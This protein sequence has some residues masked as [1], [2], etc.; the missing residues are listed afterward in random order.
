MEV[1]CMQLTSREI[2]TL[3]HS[4]PVTE[5]NSMLEHYAKAYA[6]CLLASSQHNLYGIYLLLCVQC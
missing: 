2:S 3:V 1:G 4:V 6:D 5:R